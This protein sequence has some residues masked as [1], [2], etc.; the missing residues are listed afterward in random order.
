MRGKVCPIK[1]GLIDVG[2]TPAHAGKRQLS[3]Q[4][5]ALPEDHPRPCGEKWPP[6][7]RARQ[8]RGSPP[9]MRGKGRAACSARIA[10][11]ITPAHAGKRIRLGGLPAQPKDHPRP[12]GEKSVAA[13]HHPPTTGSPP[14]MRGK[15]AEAAIDELSRRITPAH[16]GKRARP[17]VV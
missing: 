7:C 12:C 13:I 3:R 1:N 5:K 14:P 8:R 15:D 11:G 16:A 4:G 10:D 17:A 2:I 9:P 6:T